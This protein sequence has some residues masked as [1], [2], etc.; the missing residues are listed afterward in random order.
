MCRTPSI[1][2]VLVPVWI[3]STTHNPP[4]FHTAA[5]MGSCMLLIYRSAAAIVDY[6]WLWMM[7]QSINTS[8]SPRN[9]V[10][11]ISLRSEIPR[12]GRI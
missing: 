6:Q 9:A 2:A 11:V 10:Q 8:H 3:A 4:S 7:S 12:I 1:V 5:L